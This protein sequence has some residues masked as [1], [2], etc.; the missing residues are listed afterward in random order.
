MR[1]IDADELIEISQDGY[2]KVLDIAAALP[3]I[4]FEEPITKVMVRGKEYTEVVRC[5]DCFLKNDCKGQ[6]FYGD[7]GYCSIGERKGDT[8]EID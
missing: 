7:N 8:D 5:R 6:E 2:V 4:E 3:I 1:L